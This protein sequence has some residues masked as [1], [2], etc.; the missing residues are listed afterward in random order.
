ME[1]KRA[2]RKDIAGMRQERLRTS[3]LPIVPRFH[4]RLAGEAEAFVIMEPRGAAEA[5]SAVG[6]ALL[7]ERSHDVHNHVTLIELYLDVDNQTRYEDSLDLIRERLRPTAYL[8]RTDDCRLNATLL[9]RGY[10]VETTALVMLSEESGPPAAGSGSGG[11]RSG[12]GT[13]APRGAEMDLTVLTGAHLAALRELL[14]SNEKA[15]GDGRGE[16]TGDEP[17][18]PAHDHRAADPA[19][20]FAEL[21]T[22][23]RQGRNWVV[24][25]SGRPV[26][27]I[28][29]LKEGDGEHELLDFA[30]ARA[31]ES[32]LAGALRQ[33]TDIVRAEGGRP[34]AV[35]D[36]AEAARRRIFRAAGYYSA[37]AYMVF[38]DPEAGRPSVGTVSVDDLRAMIDRRERMRLVDVLGQGHWSKGHL[39]GSEW[40][41]FRGLAREARS[42]FESDEPL[43]LY[44]NGFT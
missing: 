44:C 2:A 22:L 26:A 7:L 18:A 42:R 11:S 16:G 41:D 21:E 9:A 35:I 28:A 34:A 37:A 3:A 8:A 32:E 4:A 43:V 17:A 1:L 29:R 33:A 30:I 6:Y 19:E 14:G 10:Q 27:V 25:Q 20:A 12:A 24:L 5:P 13:G 15:P 38:Y 36:A 40:I 39:P 31:G 23:V